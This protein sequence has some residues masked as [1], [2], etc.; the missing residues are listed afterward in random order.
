MN[1]I[2]IVG[3]SLSYNSY[4]Y[5]VK[6]FGASCECFADI[7]SW[8]YAVRNETIMS[9]KGFTYGADMKK[10]HVSLENRVFGELSFCG[11]ESENF[12]YRHVCSTITLYLQKHPFGGEYKVTVDDG[13]SVCDVGFKGES[14]KNHGCE[15]FCITLPADETQ[16]FHK[17]EFSGSG[18][19]TVLGMSKEEKMV[20]I[21]GKGSQKVSFFLGNYD[22]YIGCYEF[23]TIAIIVGAND[24][25]QTQ[26]RE[27]EEAYNALIERIYF[28]NPRAQIIMM[29]PTNM[30]NTE[31]PELD[32]GSYTS[33]D[34]AGAYCDII[35]RTAQNHNCVLFDTWQIFDEIPTY[36]W[37]YDNV[38]MTR[39]GNDILHKKFIEFLK[40]P[41]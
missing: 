39:L 34:T 18:I 1:S 22:E 25:R 16:G 6:P 36:V 7:H 23:D 27:F 15:L 14:D 11:T 38:H 20:T 37:R 17:V 2:L 9:T 28:Q 35:K 31:N 12:I 30:E 41:K 32:E 24:I 3:D 40:V 19:Y 21:S 13:Y 26:H 29:L 33:K 8:S 10:S 5:D 4:D